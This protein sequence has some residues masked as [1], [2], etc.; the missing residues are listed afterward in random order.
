ML[1]IMFSILAGIC[2]SLQG[3]I[4]TRAS[5]KI[6][7]TETNFIVQLSGLALTILI[8]TFFSK[9]NIKKLEA[10]NR[11]YLLGGILGVII[12]YAV[13][14]GIEN[15]GTTIAISSILIAQLTSAALIDAF[16]L[17][18][19]K[20]VPFSLTKIIGVVIMIAG[21]VIFKWKR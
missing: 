11:I 14:I 13:M 1:G 4:N 8:F 16:S 18:E 2:M 15:L 20:H 19:S 21:I 17:F 3:V 12:I 9:G 6:G 5:E 7:L 10:I